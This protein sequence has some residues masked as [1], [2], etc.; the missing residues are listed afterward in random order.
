MVRQGI[1]EKCPNMAEGQAWG[2]KGPSP[3]AQESKG[4]IRASFWCVLYSMIESHRCRHFTLYVPTTEN[5]LGSRPRRHAAS[6][7]AAPPELSRLLLHEVPEVPI[8][9]RRKPSGAVSTLERSCSTSLDWRERTEMT[10]TG[11]DV[12]SVP[13]FK[14]VPAQTRAQES[15]ERTSWKRSRSMTVARTRRVGL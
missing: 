5:S 2:E 15:A 14:T 3:D 6:S 9:G 1:D 13:T 11:A 8:L 4:R 12:G 7:L 10:L